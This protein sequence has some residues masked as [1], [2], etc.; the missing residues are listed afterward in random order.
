[1]ASQHMRLQGARFFVQPT[2]LVEFSLSSED[3]VEDDIKMCVFRRPADRSMLYAERCGTLEGYASSTTSASLAATKTPL[4]RCPASRQPIDC[5]SVF[6]CDSDGGP[7]RLL[8]YWR[9]GRH[10]H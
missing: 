5:S 7:I 3:G 10:H 2:P 8:L 1:M 9:V 4:T 6:S